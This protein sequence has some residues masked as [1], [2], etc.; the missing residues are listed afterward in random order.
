M[1]Y[2]FVKYVVVVCILQTVIW[3]IAAVSRYQ[4][5]NGEESPITRSSTYK[6]Y[7][8]K[9]GSIPSI[10]ITDAYLRE[11][12]PF[13][14]LLQEE[15]QKRTTLKE[16]EMTFVGHL[17]VNKRFTAKTTSKHSELKE[18][19]GDSKNDLKKPQYGRSVMHKIKTRSSFDHSYRAVFRVWFLIFYAWF[20]LRHNLR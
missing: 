14:P 12:S 10:E 19:K 18:K 20:T 6:L 16:N 4:R 15:S 9:R 2:F 13:T 8:K 1:N 7:T 5:N 17:N 11:H 3:N